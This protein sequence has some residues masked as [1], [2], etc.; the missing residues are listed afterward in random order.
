M[1]EQDINKDLSIFISYLDEPFKF[2]N[3]SIIILGSKPEKF[4]N[5]EAQ[6]TIRQFYKESV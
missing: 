4:K 1:M 5:I 3:K 6:Q 2:K